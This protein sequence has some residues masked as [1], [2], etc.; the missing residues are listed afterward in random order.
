MTRKRYEIVCTTYCKRGRPIATRVNDY[1]KSHRIMKNMAMLAGE[2]CEKVW[3]HGEVA[4]LLA[5]K[6]RD[7]DSVLVQR[8]DAYGN[9]KLARPCPTC[10]QALKMWGVRVVRYTSEDG[11]QEELVK[12]MK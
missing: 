7:V 1:S 11:L 4:A 8:Y 2:S 9:Q 6:D 5:S 3:L 10:R 12:D